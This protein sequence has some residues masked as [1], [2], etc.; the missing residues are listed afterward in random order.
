MS[1]PITE[2]II[3]RQQRIDELR[4]E[5]SDLRQL[6]ESDGYRK[7]LVPL[8]QR[9]HDEHV[10]GVT[11]RVGNRDAHLEAFHTMAELKTWVDDQIKSRETELHEKLVDLE[12]INR[13]ERES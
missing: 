13:M 1:D 4:S 10:A 2:Q 5:L 11:A 7:F 3:E 12:F 9:K 6:R 8:F